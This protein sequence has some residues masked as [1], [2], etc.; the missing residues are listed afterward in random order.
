MESSISTQAQILRN[1][2][3]CLCQTSLGVCSTSMG[4][5]CVTHVQA[6]EKVR[7]FS[8]RMCHRAWNESY[9]TLLERSDLQSLV[10]CRKYL[11]L[12]YLFQ[13]L[14]GHFSCLNT[15]VTRDLD[16]KLRSTNSYQLC[17]P[18]ARTH[19]QLHFETLCL[20]L[21]M[22]VTPYQRLRIVSCI[23]LVYRFVG[24]VCN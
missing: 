4:L 5:H 11:K 6:L 20:V 12:C 18:F 23:Y 22:P 13:V 24:Y 14:H 3:I 9:N 7:K 16:R 1:N 15:P 10:E 17:Q 21:H 8:F 2:F 19:M